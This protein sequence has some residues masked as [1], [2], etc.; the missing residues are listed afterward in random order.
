VVLALLDGRRK[1]VG[2]AAL[3]VLAAAPCCSRCSPPRSGA[4]A[5]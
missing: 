4:T 5:P 3:I 1:G 2:V